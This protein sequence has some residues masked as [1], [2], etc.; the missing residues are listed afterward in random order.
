MAEPNRPVSDVVCV[1]SEW[2]VGLSLSVTAT[3]G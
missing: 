2:C 3:V 1:V